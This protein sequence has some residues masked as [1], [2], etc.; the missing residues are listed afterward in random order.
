MSQTLAD[1]F[2]TAA[3]IKRLTAEDNAERQALVLATDGIPF[4][5]RG[6]R[7]LVSRFH[8]REWLAGRLPEEPRATGLNAGLRA[9]QAMRRD[10]LEQLTGCAAGRDGDCYS[11]RCPQL[12][13]GEPD[14]TGRYCP[15]AKD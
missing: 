7:L 1:E 12:R 3:E 11:D 10:P 8:C 2:L 13:D 14:A 5:Q 4:R 9:W 15:L 6:K